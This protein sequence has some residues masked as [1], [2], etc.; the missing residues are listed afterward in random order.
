MRL[1]VM[2]RL[3]IITVSLITFFSGGLALVTWVLS[4]FE[5]LAT[6][7]SVEVLTKGFVPMENLTFPV[8]SGTALDHYVAIDFRFEINDVRREAEI[9]AVMPRIRDA[10][11]RDA[12]RAAPKRT[13]GVDSVDLVRIK[14]RAKLMATKSSAAKSSRASWSPAPPSWSPNYPERSTRDRGL[15]A[16]NYSVKPPAYFPDPRGTP[17]DGSVWG[18]DPRRCLPSVGRHGIRRPLFGRRAGSAPT[19]R[20]VLLVVPLV[21]P[22]LQFLQTRG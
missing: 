16:L 2:I 15:G 5:E 1:S 22:Q 21:V 9:A 13:D 7:Q 3:V 11:V 14:E 6:G 12:H 10:I 19:T 17:S 18:R 20:R 8:N 4:N